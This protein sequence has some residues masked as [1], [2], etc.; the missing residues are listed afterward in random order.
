MA[1][2]M[3]GKTDDLY[4]NDWPSDYSCFSL[5][6]LP[7]KEFDYSILNSFLLIE[8]NSGVPRT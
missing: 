1:E 5:L 4:S 3:R 7:I 6:D 2:D 8:S